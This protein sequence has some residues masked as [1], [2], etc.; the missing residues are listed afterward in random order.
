MKTVPFLEGNELSRFSNLPG[1]ASLGDLRPPSDKHPRDSAA[2]ASS[3]ASTSHVANN[4]ASINNGGKTDLFAT[5]QAPGRYILKPRVDLES[6][7]RP[8]SESG[9][10]PEDNL[11]QISARGEFHDQT[12]ALQGGFEEK[13]PN[14]NV[15]EHLQL[16]TKVGEESNTLNTIDVDH[17]SPNVF[18]DKKGSDGSEGWVGSSSDSGSDSDNESDSSGSGSDSGRL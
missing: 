14:D 9:S 18:D 12:P 5:F 16:T 15:K 10:L 17:T 7:K 2:E 8:L 1:D 11:H 6:F 13:V 4:K 3:S